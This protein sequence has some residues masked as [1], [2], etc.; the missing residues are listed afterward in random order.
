MKRILALLIVSALL[1]G[2]LAACGGN[3]APSATPPP[4]A[5]DDTPAADDT[6]PADEGPSIIGEGGSVQLKMSTWWGGDSAAT[7]EDVIR[8]WIVHEPDIQVELMVWPW[9]EYPDMITTSFAANDAPDIL[10][11]DQTR[12]FQQYYFTG[13]LESLDS[14][15][16]ALNYDMSNW[17]PDQIESHTYDGQL[18]GVPIHR[19]QQTLW[20]NPGLFEMAGVPPLSDQPTW[21]EVRTAAAAISALGTDDEGREYKGV[22]MGGYTPLVYAFLDRGIDYVT[23]DGGLD[24][25]N[26]AVIDAF[27][28]VMEIAILYG[29]ERTDAFDPFQSNLVGMRLGDWFG[30]INETGR[31]LDFELRGANFPVSNA[32]DPQI[33]FVCANSLGLNSNGNYKDES[34]QFIF[35][36]S[37]DEAQWILRNITLSPFYGPAREELEVPSDSFPFNVGEIIKGQPNARMG[38][39]PKTPWL[40]P[41]NR[42]LSGNFVSA[43]HGEITVAEYVEDIQLAVDDWFSANR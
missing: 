22:E 4:A 32:G 17:I 12:D 15:A 41:F 31:Y 37:S 29:T 35:F 42:T 36:F 27:E 8:A 20:W 6:P 5:S 23:A 7:F 24:F 33:L 16:A 39:F 10:K 30:G 14:Y 26:P 1:V 18:V 3:D 38:T 25:D 34:A 28:T 9:N 2:V 43:R 19:E 40:L 13:I 11:M 21:D